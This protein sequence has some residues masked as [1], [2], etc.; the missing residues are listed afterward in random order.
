MSN[1][2]TTITPPPPPLPPLLPN[3]PTVTVDLKSTFL[4]KINW[5]QVLGAVASMLV[6]SS[7]GKLNISPEMQASIITAIQGVVA[8]YTVVVK[9][10]F[11]PTI[12]HLSAQVA[13]IQTNK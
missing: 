9:T 4:S 6:L 5:S 2:T 10:F 7:G 13:G 11:T 3:T 8:L 12:T 1:G